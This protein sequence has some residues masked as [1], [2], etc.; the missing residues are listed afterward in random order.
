MPIS[1]LGAYE[2]KLASRWLSA[3]QDRYDA[4][5]KAVDAPMLVITLLWFSV[6]IVP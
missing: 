3:A 6:L 1:R 2:Q 4:L 5:A